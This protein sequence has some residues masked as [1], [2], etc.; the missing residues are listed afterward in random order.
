MRLKFH[1]RESF[2]FLYT[3][4]F[5]LLCSISLLYLL[6]CIQSHLVYV[7]HS[8]QCSGIFKFFLTLSSLAEILVRKFNAFFL[9]CRMTKFAT[10]AFE[11][12][13]YMRILNSTSSFYTFLRL[14]A[15]S[16]HIMKKLR[17]KFQDTLVYFSV[18]VSPCQCQYAM[19]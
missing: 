11:Q 10:R 16:I 1:E 19:S 2:S 6:G 7:V 13:R 12:L 5:L 9:F 18:S 3:H 4:I 14:A 15:Y 17:F 8:L